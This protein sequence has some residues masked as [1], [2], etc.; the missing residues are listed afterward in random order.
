MNKGMILTLVLACSVLLGVG[1]YMVGCGQQEA[2]TTTTTTAAGATT[3]TSTTA[4]TAVGATTTT[5]TTSTTVASETFTLSATLLSGSIG[6]AGV[7][8]AGVKAYAAVPDYK[9]VVIDNASG[10]TYHGSTDAEGNIEI[11]DIPTGSSYEVSIIDSDSQYFGPVVM[12]GDSLSPEVIMGVTPS[13][14]LD[15]GQIVLDATEKFAQPATPPAS[16]VINYD[17]IAE[18]EAGKPK[19]AGNT[20]KTENTGVD[21]RGFGADIDKDGIPNLFDADEDN[22]G[23]RNGVASVPRSAT[24]NSN[25]VESV[26]ISSNIWADHGTTVSAENLI[27]MRLHVI[28]IEGQEDEIA[29]VQCTSVPSSIQNVATVRWAGSLGNPTNYP[30]ENSL[31]SDADYNLFKTTTMPEEQWIVSVCPKAIMEV[32]DVFT[33]RVTY[34]GGGYEDFFINTSYVLTDWAR[35]LSYNG[36][37][38]ST[39][40]L[41]ASAFHASQVFQASGIITPEGTPGTSK[42]PITFEADSLEIVINKPFDEDGNVLEGLNYSISSATSEYAGP[43]ED[44][45]LVP[46]AGNTIPVPDIT[47]AT[48]LSATVSTVSIETYYVTP[49]AESADGQ[50]NGEEV[51]FTK[52]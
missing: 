43:P 33:I 7:M 8:A 34:T 22:D 12:L 24:V 23:T 32:G 5:A 21:N 11:E 4:T 45:F 2:A 13:S 44:R 20:G 6:G 27:A 9:V 47:G 3:T 18:A 35:I 25:T 36:T 29:S 10:K 50:R 49:V 30:T 39:S 41:I 37:T 26:Q 40:S 28:P 31:W 1:T 17:D 51:W 19:G 42:N 48:S 14:D 38:I 15:F 52:Q 46:S 16:S